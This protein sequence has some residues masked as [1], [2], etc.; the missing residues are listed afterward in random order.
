M[1]Q[2]SE[3]Q[4][5]QHRQ[6]L[7][8]LSKPDHALAVDSSYSTVRNPQWFHEGV[9]TRERQFL[10][11]QIL[12][13]FQAEKPDVAHDK[14]AIIMAG[15]PGA[16]KTTI[17]QQVLDQMGVTESQF[18]VIDSDNFKDALLQ[19]AIADGSYESVIKPP[20]VKDLEAQGEHFYPRE[21][22][23]LVHQESSQL[24]ANART[25]AILHGEN[26][27]VDSVLS[28]P[29]AAV[30]LERQF[31]SASWNRAFILL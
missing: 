31:Q 15:P 13:E 18:H 19:H 29:T 3:Q 23:A 28:N 22:A 16:G 17:R 10:Q 5:E 11:N 25:E 1:P 6:S 7:T 14:I 27:V 24:A 2:A 12:A 26:I 21:L 8:A 20:E 4:I 30:E 9:P